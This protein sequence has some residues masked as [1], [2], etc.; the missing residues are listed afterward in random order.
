[1]LQWCTNLDRVFA[2][3]RRVLKP[4]GLLLFATFGPDTLR[5]LRESW[6]HID[7]STRVHLFMDMHDVGD[8]LI[9]TGF[10]SPVLDVETVTMQYPS[11]FDLLRDLKCIGATNATSERSRGLLSYRRLQ[12]LVNVYEERY[13]IDGRLPASYEVVYGHGWALEPSDRRQD[14]TT[15]TTFP[16]TALKVK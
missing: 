8:A 13:R 4:G 3:C 16:F 2:E 7:D 11:A 15:V 14:G 6:R 1:M 10:S 5:E 9:R 12:R